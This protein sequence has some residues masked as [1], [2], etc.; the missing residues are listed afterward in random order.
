METSASRGGSGKPGTSSK[1]LSHRQITLL[2][3]QPLK[4][5]IFGSASGPAIIQAIK[6]SGEPPVSSMLALYDQENVT[7]SSAAD[8]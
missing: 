8:F 4:L 7:C 2:T 3:A 6:A 1:S 5:K